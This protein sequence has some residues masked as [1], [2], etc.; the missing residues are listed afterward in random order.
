[1]LALG[2]PVVRRAAW[3]VHRA[4]R[5]T[6][7]RRAADDPRA[8][9]IAAVGAAGLIAVLTWL[10]GPSVAANVRSIVAVVTL[11]FGIVVSARNTLWH[12]GSLLG[13]FFGLLATF[14]VALFASEVVR[15]APAF[16][17]GQPALADY[18]LRLASFV[19]FSGSALLFAVSVLWAWRAGERLPFQR[20]VVASLFVAGI[21]SAWIVDDW[22]LQPQGISLLARALAE[23]LACVLFMLA[24]LSLMETSYGVAL[25]VM[26]GGVAA[27]AGS[28][29]L[30]ASASEVGVRWAAPVASLGYALLAGGLWLHW[31]IGR[32]PAPIPGGHGADLALSDVERVRRAANRLVEA[33]LAQVVLH[34]G[35]RTAWAVAKRLNEFAGRSGWSV[36]IDLTTVVD[37]PSSASLDVARERRELLFQTIDLAAQAVGWSLVKRA[38]GRA[39]D[40][41]WW[42]DREVLEGQGLVDGPWWSVDPSRRGDTGEVARALRHLPECQGLET[43]ELWAVAQRCRRRRVRSGRA[44]RFS[45][46]PVRR[47]VIVRGTVEEAVDDR[48]VVLGVG[49]VLPRGAPWPF[50]RAILQ[51]RAITPVELAEVPSETALAPAARDVGRSVPSVR[52]LQRVPLFARLSPAQLRR[53]ASLFRFH[54]VPPGALVARADAG[55][56]LGVVV[57]GRIGLVVE[58]PREGTWSVVDL[59]AGDLIGETRAPVGGLDVRYVAVERSTVL[60]LERAALADLIAQR[61]LDVEFAE[62]A[63]QRRSAMLARSL[64]RRDA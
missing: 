8:L 29:L 59:V 38:L 40:A 22:R 12:A 13:W 52:A 9:G 2:A 3:A 36:R 48:R 32:R 60:L 5:L 35:R 43:A 28:S 19:L 25:V 16:S 44:L 46:T 53:V 54:E 4:A 23:L 64:T 49:D 17:P 37:L 1:G 39:W 61:L 34:A 63:L 62:R 26:A 33:I 6:V 42:E 27:H 18:G 51:Y 31:R 21:V 45:S 50:G 20:L 10:V 7:W 57:S 41:L 56:P 47:W 14:Q 30:V 11:G 55:C 15:A 24:A 58:H